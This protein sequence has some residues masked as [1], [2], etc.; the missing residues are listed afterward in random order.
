MNG[1]LTAVI[2]LTVLYS[3]R[4]NSGRELCLGPA[5]RPRHAVIDLTSSSPPRSSPPSQHLPIRRSPEPL[6]PQRTVDQHHD[7]QIMST[8]YKNP[9]SSNYDPLSLLGK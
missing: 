1:G 7:A 4:S 2:D 6:L 5:P 9:G 8:F 3:P